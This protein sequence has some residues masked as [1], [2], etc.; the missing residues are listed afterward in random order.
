MTDGIILVD[1][2]AGITSFGVVARVKRVLSQQSGHK[3]KVGHCGTLD[4]F[5]T[6]LLLLCVGSS[7]RQAG[8]YMKN[9]KVYEATF[10]LGKVSSTDDPEG[11]ITSLDDRQPSIQE[12]RD[13]LKRFEGHITQRPPIYSAIKIAGQ[14]AYQR[15]RRGEDFDMPTRKVTVYSLELLDYTYP[16]VKVRVHVSSGTYIRSLAADFG[17]SLK[18]GAYCVEL[19]RTQIGKWDISDSV[20]L[21]QLG[22]TS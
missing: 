14:R 12:I 6:G 22:I 1:K 11:E 10:R 3:V 21:T 15:A 13:T 18:I 8:E 17:Q 9:D 16:D 2:P 19:R 5:A 4:P 7:C 20:N